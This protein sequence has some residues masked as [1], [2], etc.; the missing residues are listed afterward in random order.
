VS[1]DG[2]DVQVAYDEAACGYVLTVDGERAGV[3]EV[4]LDDDLAIFTHTEIA[5]EFGGRGLGSVLLGRALADVA[6]QDLAVEAR[7][8]FVSA[9]LAKHPD[10]ARTAPQTAR[11]PSE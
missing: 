3:A 1:A 11:K 10:A 9:Y 4:V 2:D 7:C 8:G 6:A 5:P